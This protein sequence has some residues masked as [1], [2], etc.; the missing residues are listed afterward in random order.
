[1][2]L[3]EFKADL[4][5][6]EITKV[7]EFANKSKDITEEDKESFKNYIEKSSKALGEDQITEPLRYIL[8]SMGGL[9]LEDL[10]ALIGE[11]F[12]AELFEQWNN[13]LGTPIFVIRKLTNDC[14]LYDIVQDMRD[15]LRSDFGE[16]SLQSCA[17][18]IGYYLFQNKQIGD[19]IRDTQCL[20]LLLDGRE[21]ATAAEYVSEV[22]GEQLRIAATILANGMKDAPEYVKETIWDMLR[23]EGEKIDTKKILMIMLNDCVAI[24]GDPEKIKPYLIRL[25]DTIQ[26]IIASG[27]TEITILLG[28]AKLRIAQ[29][30]RIRKDEQ[31]A[32]KTFLDAL[33]YLVPPLQTADPAT[34][35]DEQVHFY[36]HCLSICQEMGQP[37]AMS[38][39]FE[40]IVKIEKAQTQD[41]NRP[42]ES[43][44]QIAENIMNQHVQM[45]KAFYN[46]PKQLQDEFTNYTEPAVAL[47]KAYVE[48][49]SHNEDVNNLSDMIRLAGY[50]Q[51]LGELTMRLERY[52]ESYDALTEAQILQMRQLAAL[53][54][55]D[56]TD[57]MSHNQL[58]CRL[59]LSATNHMIAAHYRKKG[60]SQHDLGIILRSNM[61]LAE[62]CFKYHTHDPRVIHFL[63]NAALELGDYQ[64]QTR[65]YLAECGTYEKVIRQFPVLNNM[66]LD[67]QLATDVAMIHTKCGQIQADDSVRRYKD[68]IKNLDAAYRLWKAIAD[69]TK[70]PAIQQNA[71]AVL[72]MINQ[73]KGGK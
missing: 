35:S 21:A 39:L 26:Q 62:D 40:N 2:T 14:Q 71:D 66:R 11:D 42:E 37:K 52:D 6:E 30:E 70:N 13:L 25:H 36:W 23:V 22:Y 44:A 3:E 9:R 15:F 48:N 27:N 24:I 49:N 72:K 28:I 65:G 31:E 73:L 61:N 19:I 29:N 60:K 63:I 18:D 47:L 33:N 16:S 58:I 17:S 64:H 50:Y 45:S 54:K 7:K 32:Q 53:Q 46:M 56:G 10:S 43:R 34:I 1:M 41:E 4:T 20:H 38:L 55:E 59:A 51:S 69:N 8:A 67:Q 68:A 57:Q 5:E 12:N